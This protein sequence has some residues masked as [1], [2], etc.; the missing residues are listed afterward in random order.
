MSNIP[1]SVPSK[2]D[3]A[4]F[5][6]AAGRGKTDVVTEFLDKYG[7]NII[8]QRDDSG[9]LVMT[10]AAW[11]GQKDVLTLLLERGGDINGTNKDG[12]T[13]LMWAAVTGRRAVVDLLLERGASPD[14]KNKDSDTAAVIARRHIQPDI[15]LQIKEASEKR[16]QRDERQRNQ[17]DEQHQRHQE[18]KEQEE[19][20]LAT[21]AQLEKL[22]SLRSSKPLLK[23]NQPKP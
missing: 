2:E 23:K 17:A 15:E 5:F 8:N 16:R 7:E 6:D 1:P 21:Q 4:V 10:M 22:K 13:P 9:V 12:W 20:R 3:I 11:T 14:I 19:A 18:Q